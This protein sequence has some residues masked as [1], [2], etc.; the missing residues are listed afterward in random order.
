MKKI[1]YKLYSDCINFPLDRPCKYQKENNAVC[2]TCKKY[3]SINK[4]TKQTK[5]LIVKLGAMG[6]VLR[7]TFILEGLRQKYKNSTIDWLVDKKN[8]DVLVG[9]KYID[10]IIPNDNKIFEFLSILPLQS[11]L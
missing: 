10:I 7:T 1:N 11:F 6:D 2:N 3:V 4:R 8:V 5:I 9:N